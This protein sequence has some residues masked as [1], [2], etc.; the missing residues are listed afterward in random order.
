MR[1][2]WMI[3]ALC[4]VLAACSPIN[5]CESECRCQVDSGRGSDGGGMTI[6]HSEGCTLNPELYGKEYIDTF[7]ESCKVKCANERSVSMLSTRTTTC[8]KAESPD[9]SAVPSSNGSGEDRRDWL[10]GGWHVG[11]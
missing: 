8:P 9:S 1:N 5:Q 6:K 10:A 2:R 4:L 7:A 3:A 11:L